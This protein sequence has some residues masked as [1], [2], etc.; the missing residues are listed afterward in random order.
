MTKHTKT[1]GLRYT[2]PPS[3]DTMAVRLLLA[4]GA[5][6][7]TRTRKGKT[8]LDLASGNEEITQLILNRQN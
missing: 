3:T 5:D 2:E 7:S 4:R 1:E 6:A 8:A